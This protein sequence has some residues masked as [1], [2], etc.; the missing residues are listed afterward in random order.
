MNPEKVEFNIGRYGELKVCLLWFMISGIGG[1]NTYDRPLRWSSMCTI[2][3][4]SWS[5]GC[6]Q[7]TQGCRRHLGISDYDSTEVERAAEQLRR[8]VGIT[9][10]RREV[11][12]KVVP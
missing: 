9:G 12:Q 7:W 11:K 4:L 5:Q 3:A 1:I 2:D 10:R 6:S 8:G